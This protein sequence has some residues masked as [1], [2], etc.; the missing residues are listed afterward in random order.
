MGLDSVRHLRAGRGG[1]AAPQRGF[2]LG[3]AKVNGGPTGIR[4]L[5]QRI[6]SY[7]VCLSLGDQYCPEMTQSSSTIH[8]KNGKMR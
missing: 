1:P 4:T 8:S 6:M 3:I 5:N 2:F 7:W